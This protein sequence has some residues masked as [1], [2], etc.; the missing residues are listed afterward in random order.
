M[1]RAQ[2][3]GLGILILCLIAAAAFWLGRYGFLSAGF[4]TRERME[5]VE[6]TEADRLLLNM[7]YR[8][9][10]LRWSFGEGENGRGI[11]KEMNI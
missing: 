3:T 11:T 2:R 9:L 7:N 1:K 5:A 4:Q 6:Q 8:D 10:P